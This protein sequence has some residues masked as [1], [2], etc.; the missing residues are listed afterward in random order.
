MFLSFESKVSG[1]PEGVILE[2]LMAEEFKSTPE[3]VHEPVVDLDA[4]MK[5][6]G[7]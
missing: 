7:D 2:A 1:E 4:M 5:A 3:T 6:E